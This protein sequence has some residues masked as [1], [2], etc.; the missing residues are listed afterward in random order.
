MASETRAFE[1]LTAARQAALD[2][3]VFRLVSRYN[4][5]AAEAGALRS[6]SEDW[7]EERIVTMHQILDYGER[8]L[9]HA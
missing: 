9:A 2:L 4:L 6:G 7:T 8:R 1:A 5:S 3:L